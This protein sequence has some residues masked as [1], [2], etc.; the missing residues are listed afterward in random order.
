MIMIKISMIIIFMVLWPIFIWNCIHCAYTGYLIGQGYC[1][2][3]SYCHGE[4]LNVMVTIILGDPEADH[5]AGGK[6]GWEDPPLSPRPIPS[7]VVSPLTTVSRPP[8]DLFLGLRGWVMIHDFKI[9]TTSDLY[10]S[11]SDEVVWTFA[12]VPFLPWFQFYWTHFY[13]KS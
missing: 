8:Q 4:V 2:W 3:S 11:D 6:L 12:F 1:C 5:G 13:I 7:A 9:S 10:W